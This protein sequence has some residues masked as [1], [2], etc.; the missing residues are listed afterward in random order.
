[1]KK[2][3]SS[4][5]AKITAI[6]LLVV[7]TITFLASGVGIAYL[8]GCDAYTDT[9]HALERPLEYILRQDTNELHWEISN[10]A[11]IQNTTL[12]RSLEP[13]STY[14]SPDTSNFRFTVTDADGKVLA[15][16]SETP[17]EY[18]ASTDTMQL[19]L[20]SGSDSEVF[21]FSTEAEL[22]DYYYNAYDNTRTY[23]GDN[24]YTDTFL[25]PIVDSAERSYYVNVER[26]HYKTYELTLQTGV[27]SQPY[28]HDDYA[29][30]YNL[31][32][33][34]LPFRNGLIVLFALSLAVSIVLFV[35]LL[36]SAGHKAGVD[37]IYL[38]WANRIPFDLYAVVLLLLL[39]SIP[40]WLLFGGN[41]GFVSL[42]IN[43][44]IVCLACPLLALA[45][46]LSFAARAKAGGWWRNTI[47]CRLLRLVKWL[48]VRLAH[49]FSHVAKRLPLLWR[50]LVG[51]LVL[52]VVDL[53]L[54]IVCPNILLWLLQFIFLTPVLILIL[55]NLQTLEEGGQ[56]LAAGHLNHKIDLRNMLPTFRRHGEALN[57]ISEGMQT[58][59]DEQMRSERMKTE[60]IT[61]VSHDI[62]TPLTSIVT[63]VDLLKK[64]GNSEAQT[65]EYLDVLERQA[66][67]LKRLIE[68]LVEASKASTGNISVNLEP[69][70]VNVLLSQAAGEYEEKL[71]A[72]Q[73]TLISQLSPDNPTIMADGRH[74]WRVFDNL[75]GNIRK[76]A[77]DGTRV[78]LSSQVV[79]G[80]VFVTFRNIS[81]DALNISSDELL[82]RFVRGDTSRNTEGSGLGLSIAQSL[83]E[84]QHG[85]FRICVDGDLFKAE[86]TFPVIQRPTPTE[87]EDA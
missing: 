75:L 28:V 9:H 48:F 45:V 50:F 58:A 46:I 42:L 1:M 73:L 39:F 12:E 68:D 72:R 41:L 67:R 52:C 24:S 31:T 8:I 63:Y 17:P 18:L 5:A 23:T 34:L 2:L 10:F 22:W 19:E 87:A 81:R 37:G 51:W 43:L 20:C 82:E 78:Y 57:H 27:A 11:Y 80:I 56:E 29:I 55:I 83:I 35:F 84:L 54:A 61:N 21:T 60:L 70:D 38:N 40:V 16:N 44:A 25:E 79:E 13:L 6:I 49:A 36:C 47:I 86:I 77:M 3:L 14:F 74:L 59:V 76:Y 62:K 69:T 15:A 85:S 7:C 30:A 33:R 64:S 4:L 26:Y 65:A 71:A 66:A 32:S 53:I